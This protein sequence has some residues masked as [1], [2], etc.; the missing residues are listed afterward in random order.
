M[1][2]LKLISHVGRPRRVNQRG[3]VGIVIYRI[4]AHAHTL[5][6]PSNEPIALPYRARKETF[7]VA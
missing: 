6:I 4:H 1:T 5:P 7:T 2:R 3:P